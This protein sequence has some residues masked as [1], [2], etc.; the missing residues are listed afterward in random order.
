MSNCG[1]KIEQSLTQVKAEQDL[2]ELWSMAH[3]SELDT[4]YLNDNIPKDMFLPDGIIDSDKFAKSNLKVL[5]IAKEA[6]WF[7]SD[8]K[9]SANEKS[10]SMF[11]HR[12]V[13][14]GNVNKTN[15]SYRI[16]MLANAIMSADTDN[17]SVV[18]KNHDILQSVA[19]INLNKRGG[20]AYCV[21]DALSSYV[22]KYQDF[23]R[24]QINMIAPDL[25]VCC[26]YDVK[27]LLDEYKLAPN[28]RNM[29]WVYHPS[30]FAISDTDYLNQLKCAMR[31]ENWTPSHLYG[32]ETKMG[33]P[34]TKGII[35]DTNKT[36][37][38]TSTMDM[39]LSN[40]VSAYDD[41]AHL[42]DSFN[43]GDYV[44][45]SVKGTGVVAA[46]KIISDTEE[47]QHPRGLYE[48]FKVVDFIVPEAQQIPHGED[49]LQG[50][51][52]K[53]IIFELGHDFYKSRTDKRPYLNEN[54]CIKL[55]EAL[56][57]LNNHQLCGTDWRTNND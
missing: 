5:F 6:N 33:L 22:N 41:K 35:F 23:I 36:Y 2:L 18:N 52:W 28:C 47:K 56:K 15:F 20:Y 16:A 43:L 30:Y 49:K 19:F 27:W 7:Q 8:S 50:L 4:S 55:I 17:Y 44:F 39:L 32:A 46:G 3:H 45:F 34:K 42:V 29:I 51:S 21:W 9:I 24:C 1:F 10:G 13:A 25:I 53:E 48:K 26:G 31:G 54:E 38:P 11:W 57:K 14:L 12:E 40:K 37:S